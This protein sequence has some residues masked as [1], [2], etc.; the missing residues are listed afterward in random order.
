[1]KFPYGISNFYKLI[2]EGY[3]YVDR[4]DHIPLIEEAGPQLLFLRPR[5]FGKSL[6]LSMLENYYDVAQANEFERLFGHLAIG[7]NPTPLHNQYLVMKWDFSV[8]RSH[9]AVEIIERDVHDHI[10]TQIEIFARRYR[11]ILGTEIKINEAN[12]IDSFGAAVG[13]VQQSPY[14]LYLLI[15]EYDNFGNEVLMAGHPESRKRYEDLLYGEGAFKTVFKAIKSASA[16]QGLDR[17]FITG[18]SP[19]VLS[20][21][22]SGYNIAK[23][24]SLEPR[25]DDIC[26]FWETEIADALQQIAEECNFPPEKAAEALT[27]IRTF[28]NGYAFSYETEGLIYN[29]T[30][31]LYYMD[32]FQRYCQAPPNILDSN[33]AMDRAKI[34]YVARLPG[35]EQLI[36]D[37]LQEKTP[38]VIPQLEDRFGAA[39]MLAPSHERAFL[40]SLLY[41][42]GVLTLA[43]QTALQELLLRIPNL[44]VRRLYVERIRDMLLPDPG[45]RDGARETARIL[46]QTG[47]LQPLCDF[48]EQHYFN[49]LDNR[50]YR[51]ANELTLK[52]IFLTTLFDD[53]V[54][55]IDSEAELERTYADL[56]MIRRPELRGQPHVLD[57]IL[58]FKYVPLTEVGL[59]GVEVRQRPSEELKTLP[60]IQEKLAEARTQLQ[61]Y[62]QVLEEK[63]GATL[64]LRAYAV[65]ALGFERLVWEEV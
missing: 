34:A 24:I 61:R 51:W 63:Y 10:N 14:R 38:V 37:A 32:Y 3:F 27:M 42:L 39:E 8:I 7:Q 60:I 23:N 22:T 54:Y 44:V 21:V 48:I 1:M 35:G 31:A 64:Q 59:T 18:V 16:G 65:V 58:E 53:R 49:V 28:Y 5:R 13:V 52:T 41:Y 6:L 2:T 4:T 50:D 43:G 11:D 12:A 26:G 40:A 46:F 9:V 25:F 55:L 45:D 33:F 19:M 56:I 17:V 36:L 30:L 20:D 29:P 15:D 62:R 47:D 57:L